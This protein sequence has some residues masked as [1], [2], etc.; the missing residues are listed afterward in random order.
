[1][2][3]KEYAKKTQGRL[4]N[5]KQYYFEAD[6]AVHRILRHFRQEDE[7]IELGCGFGQNIYHARH[8]AFGIE[9]NPY[10]IRQCNKFGVHARIGDIQKPL[11]IK[12]ESYDGVIMSHVLEHLL[13]PN[14]AMNNA[15]KIVKPD[16]RIVVCLP[17]LEIEAQCS[18][19]ENHEMH[20]HLRSWSIPQFKEYVGLWNLKVEAVYRN[21]QRFHFLHNNFPSFYAQLNEVYGAY[22]R[23]GF[24]TAAENIFILSK[25][26]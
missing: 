7:L 4:Y 22:I 20:H 11:R 21:R 8:R 26:W 16:G 14:Y 3:S 19:R 13:Y 6:W 9:I 10:A 5:E 25:R 17:S 12:K 1:M 2:Y 18:E 15:V 24:G 23:E